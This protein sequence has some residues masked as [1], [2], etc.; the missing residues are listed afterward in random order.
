MFT[1][2]QLRIRSGHTGK[3]TESSNTGVFTTSPSTHQTV[4]KPSLLFCIRGSISLDTSNIRITFSIWLKCFTVRQPLY[5]SGAGGW[6]AKFGSRI[7]R[8]INL[9]S[10]TKLRGIHD[11]KSSYVG[12]VR[13]QCMMMPSVLTISQQDELLSVTFKPL[14]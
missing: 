1:R 6:L 2:V 10:G 11:T 13:C 9:G 3:D 4:Q 7:Q 12:A 5:Q 8:G 14:V